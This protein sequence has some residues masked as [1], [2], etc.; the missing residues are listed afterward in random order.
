MA[1]GGR[2]LGVRCDVR[3]EDSVTAFVERAVAEFGGV[4][5]IDHNAAWSHPRLDTDAV[6]V[7]LGVWDRVIET[8]TRGALLLARAA[9]PA[10]AAGRVHRDHLVGD[11]H[12]RRVDQGGL[13]G[14]E[15]GPEP[16]H[17]PPGGP[18]RAATASGP[19]PSRRGSSS[20]RRLRQ[21]CP[22]TSNAGWPRRTRPA[23][24]GLPTTSPG[25]SCSSAAAPRPT[26]T[27]RCSTWTA[28]T[29]SRDDVGAAARHD[30]GRSRDRRQPRHRAVRRGRSRPA[31]LR[32]GH[33]GPHGARGR[34]P[35]PS[36][37]AR[38]ATTTRC[39][40]PAAWT[41]PRR[42]SRHWAEPV[43]PCPWT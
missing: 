9:I 13:R 4:D 36:C 32:P 15:G 3:S 7:D 38:C 33:H 21:S 35:R 23:A 41:P 42:R 18:L 29:R 20:P 2:A 17:A 31:G 16:A 1:A 27:G 12:H 5:C 24:S 11:E 30:E 40:S 25:S 8:T 26:S 6:D 37:R 39:R 22:R 10:M 28:G 34:W 43:W 14:V 19:T